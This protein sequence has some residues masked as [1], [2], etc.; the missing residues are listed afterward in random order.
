[1]TAGDAARRL[2]GVDD[3]VGGRVGIRDRRIGI[4]QDLRGLSTP[5]SGPSP[6]KF[7]RSREPG[8]IPLDNLTRVVIAPARAGCVAVAV[9][10][11][12]PER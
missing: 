10:W 4:R 1:V 12:A 3:I 7:R 5:S 9:M 8:R 2:V 11:R 6:M